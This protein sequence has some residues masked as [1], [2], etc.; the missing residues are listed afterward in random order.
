MKTKLL[1]HLLKGLL[2]LS[3]IPTF[4][5]AQAFVELVN[6]QRVPVDRI[7]SRPDGTLAVFRDGQSTDIPRDQYVRA[8]GVRPE[9]LD[10]ATR[11]VNTGEGQ[12]AISILN[13]IFRTSA[14][15]SWD[16]RAGLLL[17][18]VHLADNNAVSARQTLEQLQ[19]RYGDQT[20]TLF[21]DL[22]ARD[23][24][25]RI[26]AGQISGLEDEL[27]EVIRESSNRELVGQAL[28]ARGDLKL[29]RTQLQPAVLDFMRAAHFFRGNEAVHARALFKA[30]DVFTQLGETSNARRFFGELRSQ[31][32]ESPYT[33]RIP[34]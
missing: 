34:Q 23:W 11:L 16:V 4:V 30:G 24:S 1:T 3:L 21:P 7:L 8:V 12:Q 9:R 32:P 28:I 6:G 10:E 26:A 25:I 5:S 19:R 2:L 22:Q 33:A 17:I 29:A 15:Q 14:Y 18:Q 27:S 13:D 31:F 20:F